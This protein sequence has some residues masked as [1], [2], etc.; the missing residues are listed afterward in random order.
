MYAGFRVRVYYCP[1]VGVQASL[2]TILGTNL[3]QCDVPK[4]KAERKM[5]LRKKNIQFDP[6]LFNI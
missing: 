3:K 1:P 2:I 6:V 5:I 4:Q